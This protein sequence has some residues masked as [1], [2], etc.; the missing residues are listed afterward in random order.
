ME[1]T[2]LQTDRLI[3]HPFTMDDA[4]DVQRLADAAEVADATL[5]IPHPYTLED[6]EAWIATHP[7]N[8][9]KGYALTFAIVLRDSDELVGAIGLHPSK[10]HNRAEVGYWIGV[11]YWNQGYA[12]EAARALLTF[13][14]EVLKLNRI[15][16][17]HY[18]RNPASGRVMQKIGMTREG[19]L[20]QHLL[21]DDRFEDS[22][23][24]GIL[25]SEWEKG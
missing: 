21:K 25:R 10:L 19:M 5:N 2:T 22:V 17:E 11:P 8:W 4:P 20:R 7:E 14:F 13:G 15:F 9:A 23:V 18:A 1:P 16:A 6:A 3:L 12:T 24:Y